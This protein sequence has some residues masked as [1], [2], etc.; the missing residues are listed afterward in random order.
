MKVLYIDA[1][2]GL[3]GDMLLASFLDLGVPLKTIQEPLFSIGLGTSFSLNLKE[4]RSYGLRGLR[5]VL[6]G[7][8]N[9]ASLSSLQKV[10]DKVETANWSN[11]LKKRVLSVFNL[12]AKAEASVHG[13]SLEK[14]HF[15]E[16]GSLDALIEVVAVCKAIDYL[17]PMK[18]ICSPPPSGSGTVETSHGFLPI[19]VPVVLEIAKSYEITLV[20]GK[21]YPKGE[22]TTP[23]GLA[24]M[25]VL[26]DEFNQP[27]YMNVKAVGI[28]LGQRNLNRS[29]FLRTCL[30]ND[31]KTYFL[32]RQNQE[33]HWESLVFQEAF[34]DDATPEDISALI[35]ELRNAGAVEVVS[36]PLQMKKGRQGFCVKA[37]VKG[38]QVEAV[39]LAWFLK[40]TTIGVREHTDGRWVLKRRGGSILTSLGKITVKQVKRP[41]G[42]ITLKPEHDDLMRLSIETGKSIEEV[43]KAVFL[44]SNEFIAHEDWS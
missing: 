15:H 42:S 6:D 11:L 39:R 37:I 23:T 2:T 41:N 43:R 8:Q 31:D 33:M 27:N 20:G 32:G 14:V 35:D 4:E 26:A 25:A 28:G 5:V 12:L 10:I 16:I 18:I 44:S 30:I 21:D 3:A 38:D 24:L 19:P 13:T 36:H 17:K 7:L 34:I 1:P 29:N 40:G 22:L 9:H